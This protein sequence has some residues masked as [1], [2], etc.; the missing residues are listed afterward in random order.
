[1]AEIRALEPFADRTDKKIIKMFD[2]GAFSDI[3]KA[4]CKKSNAKLQD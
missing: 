4:Y 3:L 1:M 2:C